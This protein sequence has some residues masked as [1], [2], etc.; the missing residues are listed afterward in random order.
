MFKSWLYYFLVV[1]FLT[2]SYMCRTLVATFIKTEISLRWY[3]VPCKYEH[4]G[5]LMQHISHPETIINNRI[6]Q[7]LSW[8]YCHR[9]H[10]LNMDYF[11]PSTFAS[12]TL[13]VTRFIPVFVLIF[14]SL[15]QGFIFCRIR[16]SFTLIGIS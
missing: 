8:E 7:M 16:S 6:L 9:F 1:W 3:E 10:F 4:T 13:V 14:L 12:N 11:T 5:I 15:T 2:S